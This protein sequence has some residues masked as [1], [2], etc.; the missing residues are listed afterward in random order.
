MIARGRGL[1]GGRRSL[2]LVLWFV[3][4]AAFLPSARAAPPRLPGSLSPEERACAASVGVELEWPATDGPALLALRTLAWFS[5]FIVRGVVTNVQARMTG[6]PATIVT[7][8]VHGVEKGSVPEE[9]I[10]VIA[11]GGPQFVPSRG[12]IWVGQVHGKPSYEAGEE[13]LLFL[14]DE[15]PARGAAEDRYGRGDYRLA[16][17]AKYLVSADEVRHALRSSEVYPLAKAL[18]EIRLAVSKQKTLCRE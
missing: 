3:G 16:F 11:P 7:I 2:G 15:P 18:E 13:V 17:G 4:I 12:Q 1:H 8:S 5:P 10:R 6:S 9:T 14:H